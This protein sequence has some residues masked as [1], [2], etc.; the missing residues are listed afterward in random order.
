[1]MTYFLLIIGFIIL[2]KGAD[3][4][5]EGASSI[6]QK[7]NVS[8]LVIGLTVVAFGTSAPEM[9]V[10]VF[11][12]IEGNSNIAI[13]NILGSNIANIFLIL[14]VSAMI[15]PLAVKSN[16]VWK[17]IPFSLLAAV[18]LGI[19]ANDYLIDNKASSELT[20]SDGLVLLGFFIIF[21]YYI[22]S[23]VKKT[24]QKLKEESPQMS[25]FRAVA[26]ILLGLSGLVLGGSWIVDAAVKIASQFGVSEYLIG[27]TVVA[28]GTSLPELATSAM[29]AYKRNTDIAIGNVVGSNIFNI[30]WVL[31]ISA[32][33]KPLPFQPSGNSEIAMTIVASI[34]LF[35]VFF[36]GK[37]HVLEK[38]QGALFLLL[39]AGYTSFLIIRG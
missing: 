39:Y 18:I 7:L 35:L 28:V 12:S 31:G 4:L 9:F 2:I 24:E 6:A 29:A 19:L 20:R 25:N 36:V 33:I 34:L 11:A 15:Y 37:K 16:T 38:W 32:L 13:G 1:M 21:M 17:E 3:L 27:L 10:N 5:V 30:F 8:D 23:I 14:G 26:Y 22:F